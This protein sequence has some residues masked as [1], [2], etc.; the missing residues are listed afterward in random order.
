M[1]EGQDVS[2]ICG[3]GG[4]AATGTRERGLAAID[5]RGDAEQLLEQPGLAL[6]YRF[7]RGRPNK[8][9]A[10]LESESALVACAGTFAPART[11]PAELIAERL[12]L[13]PPRFDGLDGAFAFAHWDKQARVLTLG[14]DCFGVR[15]LYY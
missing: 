3:W 6:G 2:G 7:W 5:Y 8:A 12:R 14:R 15:S 9:D 11:S 13:T 4:Q 10:I 1:G